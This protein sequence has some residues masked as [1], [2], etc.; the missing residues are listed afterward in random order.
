MIICSGSCI[1]LPLITLSPPHW[2]HPPT[3]AIEAPSQVSHLLPCP[4]SLSHTC[5][6]GD[7]SKTGDHAENPPLASPSL[8]IKPKPF[9]LG[10]VVLSDTASPY[11]LS[12][13]CC[14]G[15]MSVPTSTVTGRGESAPQGA[16]LVVPAKESTLQCREHEFNPWSGN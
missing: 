9:T 16:S 3:Q 12:Q 14:E 11:P 7:L 1:L 2:P 6:H 10:F 8:R 13:D 5:S 15:H 4:Q